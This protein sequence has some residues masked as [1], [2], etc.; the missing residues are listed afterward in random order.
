MIKLLEE[1]LDQIPFR[2]FGLVLRVEEQMSL[3]PY[4]GATI[5]G[6]FGNAFKR[7]VCVKR[8][9]VCESCL[10]RDQCIYHYSF[11]TRDL[12]AAKEMGRA[13]APHPFIIEPPLDRREVFAVG[14]EFEVGLVLIGKAMDHL[15]YFIY[16]FDEMAQKGLGRG[17]AKA[18]LAYVTTDID[19][20]QEVIYDAATGRLRDT[21]PG[22]V[23]SLSDVNVVMDDKDLCMTFDTPTRLKSAGRLTD[24]IGF[25]LL[26]RSLLRR[27]SDLARYHCDTELDVDYGAIIEQAAAVTPTYKRLQWLDWDRYSTRQKT[28]M[29]LGGIV[30]EVG[31]S[32]SYRPFLPL[33]KLGADLHVGKATAF[34][35]GKYR[36]AVEGE[37]Y[38]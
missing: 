31:F 10:I 18:K 5:R 36:I 19:E 8:D 37:E 30:G 24:N 38:R 16:A 2:R 25:P 34:G 29:R 35:L 33:L 26:V 20:K 12:T 28:A 21:P 4:K 17:R 9:L 27:M 6:A 13:F 1:V 32:G 15:P 23:H 7:L 11:E 14:E 22:A 3:P